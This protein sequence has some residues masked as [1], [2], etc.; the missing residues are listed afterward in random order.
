MSRDGCKAIAF[1]L[2]G[3]LV[4][5]F[6][7]ANLILHISFCPLFPSTMNAIRRD[8][9]TDVAQH[10]IFLEKWRLEKLGHDTI[11]EEWKL[12]TEW[13]EKDVARHIREEDE[14]QEHVR[15]E[16][17]REFER[18]AHEVEEY[19]KMVAHRVREEQE[20]QQ[21]VREEWAREVEKH[22]HE[23]EEMERREHER[24]ES[25]RQRWQ[26]EVENH[27]RIEKERK[28]REDEERQKLNMFWGGIEAHTCTTYA[29]RD[30]TAQLMN[31]PTTWEHRVEACKATPLEVH[32]VSYLPKSCEDKASDVNSRML[33]GLT[34]CQGPGVVIG[35]W[36]INQH[37][38]DCA[39]FWLWYKDKEIQLQRIEHYL[40]NLPRGSD[41]REFCA[42]TP[43]HFLGMEFSGA[44]ECFQYVRCNWNYTGDTKRFSRTCRT[45]G[46]TATGK[47]MTQAVCESRH[48]AAV[49]QVYCPI[50]SPFSKI[51]GSNDDHVQTFKLGRSLGDKYYAVHFESNFLIV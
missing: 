17:A 6:I 37:E 9:E 1:G 49:F 38:A 23:W 31:L 39:T 18:H 19:E 48:I 41:W 22:R 15:Q 7:S 51:S 27:D 11:E 25:G 12:E 28:K 50:S 44:Q 20:R 16:W 8:W 21:R 34:S 13:H 42:T 33:S 32:G 30:Y 45:W 4:F 36:E 10:D 24:R 5:F 43:V 14:R 29:T 2:V 46:R 40:E 26:R 35:R 47:S 3:L